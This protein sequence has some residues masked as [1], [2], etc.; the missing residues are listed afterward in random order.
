MENKE[1]RGAILK[2]ITN[3]QIKLSN[4]T[5]AIDNY[6]ESVRYNEDM[7]TCM[8]LVLSNLA[9]RKI[10]QTKQEFGRIHEVAQSTE[11][12]IDSA[13]ESK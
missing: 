2:N 1:I 6:K 10:D 7:R 12:E 9:V 11:K 5:D 13:E 3:A 8:N 4:F